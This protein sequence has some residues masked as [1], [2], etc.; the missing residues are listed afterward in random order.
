MSML[1]STFRQKSYDVKDF[2]EAYLLIIFMK[3]KAIMKSWFAGIIKFS[4]IL[5]QVSGKLADETRRP[6]TNLS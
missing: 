5:C 2:V 6:N 1:Q 3:Y 4:G